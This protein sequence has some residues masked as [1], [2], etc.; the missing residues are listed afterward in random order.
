MVQKISV[1]TTFT[2]LFTLVFPL[3]LAEL[4]I[5]SYTFSYRKVLV[6]SLEFYVTTFRSSRPEVLRKKG[7][8]RKFLKFTGK[9]LCQSLFCQSLFSGT[10]VFLWILWNFQEHLFYRTPLV[11]ASE[12]ST[13]TSHHKREQYQENNI[14][15]ELTPSK[16]LSIVR[17][18]WI[19]SNI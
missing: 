11:A 18:I 10:R 15:N 13:N 2:S 12:R 19:L 17:I 3:S 6:W 5:F 16:N 9:H 4:S 14:L 7:V 8:L 1:N